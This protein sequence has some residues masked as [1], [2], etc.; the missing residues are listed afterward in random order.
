MSLM[1]MWQMPKGFKSLKDIFDNEEF[2]NFRKTV[3]END[4]VQLL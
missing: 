1:G 2:S 3:K 4:Q